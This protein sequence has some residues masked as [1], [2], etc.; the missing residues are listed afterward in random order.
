MNTNFIDFNNPQN[1]LGDCD[2]ILLDTC[3]MLN[4]AS[5]KPDALKFAEF[6]LNNDI[7]FCYTSKS[8]EELHI[9]KQAKIIPKD[10]REAAPNMKDFLIRSYNIS[11]NIINTMNTLPNMYPNPI[12]SIDT[13]IMDDIQTNS[14]KHNLRWPD[15]T[16]FTLAKKND[17]NY[18]WTYDRDWV[19]VCD[20]KMTILTNK[21]FIPE[22]E[23]QEDSGY[24]SIINNNNVLKV[25]TS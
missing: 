11:N 4:L 7:M 20:N 21:R 12:G 15:A 8:I 14:K 1:K 3:T 6:A 5:R 18:I 17:I 13:D 22:N 16:I 24:K 19:N 10:K 25:K 2:I 9:M 23:I